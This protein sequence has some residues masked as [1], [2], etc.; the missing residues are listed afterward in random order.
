MDV[1]TENVVARA[2]HFDASILKTLSECTCAKIKEVAYITTITICITLDQ[3]I[4]NIEQL[5]STYAEAI[6]SPESEVSQF[7]EQV[8][9]GPSNFYP[10]QTDEGGQKKEFL[11]CVVFTVSMRDCKGSVSVK[12]FSN[13]SL[14]ITGVKSASAAITIA[15][16]FCMFFALVNNGEV[17][18]NIH[19]FSVQLINAHFPFDISVGSLRLD[20]LFKLLL[21]ESEHLCMYNS[22]R[23][24]GVMIK[25]LT[26]NMKTVTTIVFDTGNVLICAFCNCEDYVAAWTFVTT[27]IMCHWREVW[28][29]H[30][31]L[32]ASKG[33]KKAGG[34]DYGKYLV[35]K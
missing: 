10:K 33:K 8:Y 24:A 32:N 18:H 6:Q 26:D 23:H 31:L 13:G 20:V 29:P 25:I 3:D 22:E 12:C 11:N 4:E 27:F 35:L 7:I 5:T 17:R 28:S 21:N 1:M 34:F 9:G 19:E 2:V 14:H 15:R 16:S 30:R